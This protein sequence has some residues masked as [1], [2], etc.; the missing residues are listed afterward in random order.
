VP[1]S[2]TPFTDLANVTAAAYAA[3]LYIRS[4][5]GSGD[6]LNSL[7][8]ARQNDNIAAGC[9]RLNEQKQIMQT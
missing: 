7:E 6:Y 3:N 1:H 4:I 8:V 9:V 5:D 2:A